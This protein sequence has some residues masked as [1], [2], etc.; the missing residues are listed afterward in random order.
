MDAA[1]APATRSAIARAAA[2]ARDRN[3]AALPGRGRAPSESPCRALPTRGR[4]P[5]AS[6]C[7]AR[8][9][10]RPGFQRYSPARARAP[11]VSCGRVGCRKRPPGAPSRSG[12]R[13]DCSPPSQ[14]H[15]FPPGCRPARRGRPA[16][17][18]LPLAAGTRRPT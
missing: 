10:R 9:T 16:R 12:A 1:R 18:Q 17:P 15:G 4:S 13:R 14:S 5:S 3:R 2:A 11:E 6:G 8:S 7:G